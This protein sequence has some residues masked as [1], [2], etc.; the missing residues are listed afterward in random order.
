MNYDVIVAGAGPAGAMAALHLSRA[1]CRVL[2]L[3]KER[4]G[5][6]K[7]RG[8]GLTP[9]AWRGLEVPIDDLVDARA[10]GVEPRLGARVA[11]RL[12]A[13]EAT[14]LM[15]R[16]AA[17]DRRLAEAAGADIHE[18]EPVT[19]A[20]AE[21][22][23]VAVQTP[24]GRYTAEALL[25]ATG[26]EGRLRASLGFAPPARSAVA[27]EVEGTARLDRPAVGT[28]VLDYAVPGGYAWAF[29]K[30]DAWNVGV[31]WMGHRPTPALRDQLAHFLDRLGLRFAEPGLSASRASGRRI[32]FWD[33][34]RTLARGR[35][36]LLGDAAGL[37][38]AFFGEG[39]APALASGRLAAR[40]ALDVLGGRAPYLDGYS[41]AIRAA[42]GPHLDRMD[43][44]AHLVM[45]A[46]TPW[47]WAL[48]NLQPARVLAARVIAEP[49]RE[50]GGTGPAVP[51]TS[52]PAIT[53]A[54]EPGRQLSGATQP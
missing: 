22:G 15:V 10:D 42:L 43:R 24:R 1:G 23:R 9:R 28:A 37:A 38:D 41:A 49:F 21:A 8:G 19:A 6:D 44:L 53:R 26:A 2:L 16:R 50:P 36:A 25:L 29:P 39:I 40:A 34:R 48:A 52:Y 11:A 13:P 20:T 7:S 51:A 3:E 4:L 17:F 31:G 18:A 46:P 54:P 35:V 12:R 27:I 30:G 33:R 14:I 47:L 5:R 45:P 32:P